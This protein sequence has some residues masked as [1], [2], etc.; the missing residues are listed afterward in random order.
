VTASSPGSSGSSGEEW[1]LFRIVV[2]A[3]TEWLV[4][5]VGGE[6]G[7]HGYGECSDAGALDTVVRELHRYADPFG[8]GVPESAD[9]RDDFVTVTVRGGVEQARLDRDARRAGLALHR[10]LFG[11]TTPAA[12]ELYANINRAPGGRTPQDVAAT[13]SAAV[14]D[15]FRAV[16]LAPFDSPDPAGRRTLAEVGL[17]RVRAVR[18]AVGP[19]VD[20]MVDAHQRLTLDELTPLLGPFE[21]LGLYWLEDGVG[22]EHPDE[23]A[24]LRSRTRLRLA[25][26]EFAHR[27]RDVRAVRGLLDVLLPDVKHAG[28]P[29]AAL[30]LVDEMAFKAHIS[31]HNP[32]GP[33]ATAHAAHLA[34]TDAS[35]AERLEYA[36]GE[37]DWRAD[38]VHGAE[39]VHG[40]RL[41]LTDAP[42]IGLELDTE[43]P[44][45]TRVWSG[46]LEPR[47]SCRS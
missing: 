19:G 35:L 40:G 29:L 27:R 38:V 44:A 22:I 23:L 33:V 14:R 25:G 17:D 7:F 31:L 37:V 36:Y 10:H 43:H 2:S 9:G 3:R 4:L 41:T 16:K 28:G 12:V 8:P 26:G 6:D 13:A 1:E 5:R 32:C 46:R 20:V 47:P 34:P 42:G 11:R 30:D 15:G 45:V 21:D 39:R 18:E 24:E